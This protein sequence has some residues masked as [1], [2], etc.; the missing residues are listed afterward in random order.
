MRKR[1]PVLLTDKLSRDTGS[2]ALQP[3][4]QCDQVIDR[5]NQ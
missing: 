5:E 1:R 3:V 2:L 4:S